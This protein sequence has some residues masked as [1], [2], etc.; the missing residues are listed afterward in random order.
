LGR[1]WGCRLG[2]SAV[3][4]FRPPWRVALRLWAWSGELGRGWVVGAGTA[5]V[6]GFNGGMVLFVGVWQ[7]R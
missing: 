6:F 3:V 1:G 5:L 4:L 7:S 2:M